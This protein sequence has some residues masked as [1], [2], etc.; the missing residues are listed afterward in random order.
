MSNCHLTRVHCSVQG[1]QDQLLYVKLS[2]WQE[3]QQARL[4]HW[5]S[6]L[7]QPDKCPQRTRNHLREKSDDKPTC[8][9]VCCSIRS[10]LAS[11]YACLLSTLQLIMNTNPCFFSYLSKTTAD[12]VGI[13]PPTRLNALI[14]PSPTPAKVKYNC[15]YSPSPSAKCCTFIWWHSSVSSSSNCSCSCPLHRIF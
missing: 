4:F 7:L 9:L 14:V 11:V 13:L 15:F 10:L 5:S 2:H 1:M 12:G 8:M 6:Y 3:W